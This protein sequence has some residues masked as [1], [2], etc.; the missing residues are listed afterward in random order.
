MFFPLP[1]LHP[2]S[3]H[4]HTP[5]APRP[6]DQ[7]RP[8]GAVNCVPWR[9]ATVASSI[10]VPSRAPPPTI[11][12]L[13]FCPPCRVTLASC[14]RLAAKQNR[15][16]LV[17]HH[18]FI[19]SHPQLGCSQTNSITPDNTATARKEPDKWSPLCWLNGPASRLSSRQSSAQEHNH[20]PL[21]RKTYKSQLNMT[22]S[23]QAHAAPRRCPLCADRVYGDM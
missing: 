17:A 13:P 22:G 12:A 19:L 10:C 6:F 14:P 18:S 2:V 8:T 20:Q 23:L 9:S 1:S 4:T 21:K 15:L 5:L 3:D 11:I 7:S 16:C